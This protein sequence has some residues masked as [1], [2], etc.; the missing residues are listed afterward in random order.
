MTLYP[1]TKCTPE[2]ACDMVEKYGGERMMVNSAGDWGRSDPMAVP[3]FILAMRRR[4]HPES[5]IRKV[6]FENPLA[7]W[8]KCQRWPGLS[9]RP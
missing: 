7:F 5:L 1:V 6:A 3:E 2:R 9:P 4:G 8:Q